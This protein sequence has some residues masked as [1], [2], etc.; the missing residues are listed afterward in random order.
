M[1][2]FRPSNGVNRCYLPCLALLRPRVRRESKNITSK[3]IDKKLS[4]V[5]FY[6]EFSEFCER[7]LK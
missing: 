2:A 4:L 7:C 1:Q 6:Y 5:H 3:P